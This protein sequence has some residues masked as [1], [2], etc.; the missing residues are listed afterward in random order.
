MDGRWA[1]R[2]ESGADV[3]AA[4]PDSVQDRRRSIRPRWSAECHHLAKRGRRQ[5]LERSADDRRARAYAVIAD[6]CSERLCVLGEHQGKLRHGAGREL[7]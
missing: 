1:V 3:P 2:Q 5:R 4:T 6:E 7:G